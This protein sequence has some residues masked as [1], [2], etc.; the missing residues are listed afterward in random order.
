MTHRELAIANLCFAL[1]LGL[2]RDPRWWE[3]ARRLWPEFTEEDRHGLGRI[4]W[5]AAANALGPAR[6]RKVRSGSSQAEETAEAE[7][8]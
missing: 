5:K 1:R 8:N 4:D 3:A 2:Y 6:P 7:P